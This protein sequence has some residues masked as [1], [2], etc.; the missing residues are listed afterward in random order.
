M[1]VVKKWTRGQTV[2]VVTQARGAP[3]YAQ[4]TS[5]GPKY[6]C[7]HKLQFNV[8]DGCSAT[9]WSD[10]IYT[11]DEWAALERKRE[12]NRVLQTAGVRFE[13]GCQLD[14]EAVLAALQTAGL[15]PLKG[16]Q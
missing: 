11:L 16:Q 12:V 15:I 2:V 7:A 6:V 13:V 10:R 14:R 9:G 1:S 3:H 8:H 5:V 4:V